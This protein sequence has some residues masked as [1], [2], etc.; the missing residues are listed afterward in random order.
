MGE[1]KWGSQV[2][3]LLFPQGL[4]FLVTLMLFVSSFVL[5]ARKAGSMCI[6]NYILN[7]AAFLEFSIFKV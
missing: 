2:L 4:I 6:N 3:I 5:V 1:E 7:L